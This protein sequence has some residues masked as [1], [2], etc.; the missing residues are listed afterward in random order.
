M[1]T[2]PTNIPPCERDSS[3]RIGDVTCALTWLDEENG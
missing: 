1:S 2:M 3:R